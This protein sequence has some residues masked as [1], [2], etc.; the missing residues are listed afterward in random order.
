[1]WGWGLEVT[2]RGCTRFEIWGVGKIGGLHK[3]GGLGLLCQL[4]SL[5]PRHKNPC[6]YSFCFCLLWLPG[7]VAGLTNHLVLFLK[8]AF[9]ARCN[10]M[11]SML[12][13][14]M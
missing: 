5:Y 7:N 13:A 8:N 1:M 14:F 10:V 4:C 2:E 12:K 9:R 11:E 6:F 3:I